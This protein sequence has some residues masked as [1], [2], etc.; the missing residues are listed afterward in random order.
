MTAKTTISAKLLTKK[1][2]K[3][4]LRN[5]YGL[6]LNKKKLLLSVFIDEK[7]GEEAMAFLNSFLEAIKSLTV[8]VI[9]VAPKSLKGDLDQYKDPRGVFILTF[10]KEAQEKILE[11]SDV[12]F[13]FPL[14]SMGAKEIQ[15]MWANGVIPIAEESQESVMD[16][17]PNDETGNSFTIRKES[18]WSIFAALVRATETFRFPYDWKH[19]VRQILSK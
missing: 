12:S 17:D 16:Y 13:V 10:N 15:S 9:V 11:A 7:H 14:T 5:K 1:T 19:I 6:Q 18:I 2:A 4:Y 8:N 3:D